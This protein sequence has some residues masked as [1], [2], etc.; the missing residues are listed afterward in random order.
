MRHQETDKDVEIVEANH[1]QTGE[2]VDSYEDVKERFEGEMYHKQTINYQG[3]QVE[4]EIFCMPYDDGVHI[5]YQ[6]FIDKEILEGGFWEKSKQEWEKLHY[7]YQ[8]VFKEIIADQIQYL[9][10]EITS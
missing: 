6:D 3:K 8:G 9:T 5:E 1:F 4:Y 2:Y 7:D 10:K